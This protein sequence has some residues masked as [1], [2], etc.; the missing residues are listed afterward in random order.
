MQLIIKQIFNN[1]TA[2]VDLGDNQQAIVKGK[3]IGFN[4]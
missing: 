4:K 1:N 3:G 2:I